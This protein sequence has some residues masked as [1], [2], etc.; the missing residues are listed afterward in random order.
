MRTAAKPNNYAFI[1]SQNL[2][3][4]I[5]NLGWKL[6]YSRFRRY[7]HDKYHVSRAFIFIGY[8]EEQAQLYGHLETAGYELI[9]KPTLSY[10]DG[11]TKGNVDAELVMHTIIELPHYH[12]A[13]IVTGDG[14]FYSLIDYLIT[15]HRLA[16]LIIPSQARYSTLLKRIDP[17]HLAFVSDLRQ[18]LAYT[19]KRKEPQT[20]QPAE[21]ASLG[22]SV[23]Q[24]TMPTQ[25]PQP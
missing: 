22:D 1:D 20:D 4:S 23:S 24:R 6:D 16:K 8:M 18:K 21:G 7:L 5:Q 12:Q 9:Y 17:V 13:V 10:K 14:D 3:L 2:N 19:H 11:S 15:Q 25:P